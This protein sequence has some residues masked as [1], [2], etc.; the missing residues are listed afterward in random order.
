MEDYLREAMD[1]YFMQTERGAVRRVNRTTGESIRVASMTDDTP[2][3]GMYPTGYNPS[4]SLCW[5]NIG[6]SEAAHNGK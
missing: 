6:H 2:Y 3:H 5:L 4:C 1:N